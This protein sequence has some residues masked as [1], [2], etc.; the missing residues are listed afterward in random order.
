MAPPA[1]GHPDHPRVAG[2][3]LQV[4]LQAQYQ[5][6]L[7]LEEIDTLLP[8]IPDRREL[9]EEDFLA[10]AAVKVQIEH[11]LVL[12]ALEGLAIKVV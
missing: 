3:P 2:S 10:G 7:E 5:P 9:L 6:P 1:A 8:L 12:Q 11:L 4:R